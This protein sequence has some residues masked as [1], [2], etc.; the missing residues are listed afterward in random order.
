VP[1]SSSFSW[2][3]YAV[4]FTEQW[5]AAY[6]KAHHL[7]PPNIEYSCG[8]RFG[9]IVSTRLA[10]PA[11]FRAGVDTYILAE[12]WQR[13]VR[14]FVLGTSSRLGRQPGL[15]R[16]RARDGHR[17]VMTRSPWFK[18][19]RRADHIS[20]RASVCA[21]PQSSCRKGAIEADYE[22]SSYAIASNLALGPS[23][24]CVFPYWP[25]ARDER[26]ASVSGPSR[27]RQHGGSCGGRDAVFRRG[28][29]IAGLV[30][31]HSQRDPGSSCCDTR[32]IGCGATRRRPRSQGA[33][34]LARFPKFVMVS[35]SFRRLR[36][37]R[38]LQRSASRPREPV[39]GIS[40]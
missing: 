18:T 22:D 9:L 12:K 20:P 7:T 25:R 28:R 27:G 8:Y 11:I 4:K 13:P 38:F 36:R 26:H 39:G 40:S 5:L 23:P 35:W 32:C 37:R 33:V 10:C 16:A 30:Q 24:A 19:V 31:K 2:S 6:G 14:A 17:P 34:P 15:R 29:K 1:A 3:A 21:S